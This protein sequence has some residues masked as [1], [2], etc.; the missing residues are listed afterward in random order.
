MV[1]KTLTT[2]ERVGGNA[3]RAVIRNTVNPEQ[4]L[5]DKIR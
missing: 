2:G 5:L 4:Q 1:V 3:F